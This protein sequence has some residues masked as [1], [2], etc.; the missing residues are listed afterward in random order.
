MALYTPRDT[1]QQTLDSK[2]HLCKM[3]KNNPRK[4][5][6]KKF[7]QARVLYVFIIGFCDNLKQKCDFTLNFI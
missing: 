4:T 7:N 2:M 3:S 1:F 6:I 5:P